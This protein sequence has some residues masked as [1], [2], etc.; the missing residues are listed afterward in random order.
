MN[1]QDQR[2]PPCRNLCGDK[3]RLARALHRPPLTQSDLA[4]RLQ[5]AGY[6]LTVTKIS[7]IEKK[8]RG[9]SDAELCAFA[10]ALNV[11]VM[12]LLDGTVRLPTMA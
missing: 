2:C 4:V 3:I 7:R 8:M 10:Q 6:D 5:L 9:I 11:P 1:Q 12:W